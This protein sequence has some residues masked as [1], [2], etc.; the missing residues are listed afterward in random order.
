MNGNSSVIVSDLLC[1][2]Q[3]KIDTVH[4]ESLALIIANFYKQDCIIAAREILYKD[5]P[6]SYP[7]VV[8]HL[9]KKDNVSA[10]YDVMQAL[11]SDT[12]V[13]FV[14]KDLNNVPPITMKNV[15]PVMLLKQT[16]SLKEE[17]AT[18]KENYDMISAQLASLMETLNE[19]LGKPGQG[20][21]NNHAEPY[22]SAVQRNTSQPR[23]KKNTSANMGGGIANGWPRS[24]RQCWY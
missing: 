3:C 2:M 13:S 9:N 16:S 6:S 21:G 14:C 4:K 24:G 1:Y 17:M 10:M 15:D 22:S 20:K 18:M 7:R 19:T 11:L 23:K 5:L 12:S 8:R